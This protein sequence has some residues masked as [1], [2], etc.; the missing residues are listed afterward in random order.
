MRLNILDE[1]MQMSIDFNDELEYRKIRCEPAVIN[2]WLFTCQ[3]LLLLRISPALRKEMVED[4][5]RRL[6]EKDV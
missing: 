4:G 3:E 1:Q 5:F 2:E 6:V